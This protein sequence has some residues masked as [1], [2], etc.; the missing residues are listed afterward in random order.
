[1]PPFSFFLA[2]ELQTLPGGLWG[3]GLTQNRAGGSAFAERR[4]RPP[5][6][7]GWRVQRPV[8]AAR[9]RIQRPLPHAAGLRGFCAAWGCDARFGGSSGIPPPVLGEK[10]E[11]K[12]KAAEGLARPWRLAE[13]LPAAPG[14]SCE[15][16]V[17]PPRPSCGEGRQGG[18]PLSF[19]PSEPTLP[20]RR[21]DLAPG[22]RPDGAETAAGL[23]PRRA[24]CGGT[25]PHRGGRWRPAPPG[26]GTT[27]PSVPRGSSSPGM[28]RPGEPAPLRL[29]TATSLTCGERAPPGGRRPARPFLPGRAR[30][31]CSVQ[32]PRYAAPGS[33][34]RR[35]RRRP[36]DPLCAAAVGLRVVPAWRGELQLPACCAARGGLPGG[37][38]H[39]APRRR[40]RQLGREGGGMRLSVSAAIS[41]GRV[42]RRLGLGPRSRLDLL[43]NLVTA[44][45]RHERIE[46]PW[47]RADEM[48]GYAER[49]SGRA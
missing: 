16:G 45:V 44:L 36:S 42:H 37:A 9:G 40:R 48:R 31:P 41:H 25:R 8:G 18:R 38:S 28:P 32:T 10:R 24:G 1:M 26:R 5:P 21:H 22:G 46:A 17:P 34:S 33:A 27:A 39:G 7:L 2:A 29:R 49:V 19:L 3:R 35:A 12:V 30:L 43:R 14:A 23:L 47:A 13:P 6:L 15:G 4:Q 11:S 20:A